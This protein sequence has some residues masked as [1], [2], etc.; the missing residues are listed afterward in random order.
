MIF[1]MKKLLSILGIILVSGFILGGCTNQP[2]SQMS[3]QSK[4]ASQT[5]TS[6][7]D[8]S[9]TQ[10]SRVVELKNGDSYDLI[11]EYA[12]QEI[13]G[14][15]YKMLAYNGSI[16]GP[17]LKVQQGSEITINLK[18]NTDIPTSLHSHGVRL[19]DKYDGVVDVQQ[20]QID[21]G[22][23]FTYKIKF[24]DA[25]MFWYHPH[26]NEPYTQSHGLYGAYWVVPND[27]NYWSP[28]NEEVPLMINDIAIQNG[29]TD[30][31]NPK[32]TN[33][34]LMGEFGN[35]MLVNGSTNYQKPLQLGEVIRLYAVNA[36]NTRVYNLSIPNV[37]MKLVGGDNGKYEHET[38][39]DHIVLSPSERAIVDVLF[40][41]SGSY[42][43]Q[44]TN[45]QNTYNLGTFTVSSEKVSQSFAKEF[46]TLRDNKDI[47]AD[48]DKYRDAFNKKPDKSITLTMEMK[49]MGNSGQHMM[50][51][52]QMMS[53]SMEQ[54]MMPNGQMMNNTMMSN[55]QEPIEW[56]DTM[57]MMNAMSTTET[58]KWKI[59]DDATKK[60]N[61]DMDWKFK[62][63][64][65]IKVK[66]YNDQN[67]M[68]PMQHPIHFHGQRFLVLSTNG[69]KNT[70]LVWKD[71]ALI[72][73]GATV[74]ILV[75]MSN[76]GKWMAH[77]HIAE[78]LSSGM[79]F[80]FAVN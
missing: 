48:I 53:N 23:T 73:K 65:K 47:I 18:N 31:F 39:Q 50:P 61:M 9:D 63:G 19:E 62:V 54:H 17:T 8:I 76:P 49:G 69:V 46:S 70:N 21:P 74:E 11:A 44:S 71:T 58:V 57:A 79:M 6:Q 36:S 66:I 78:H 1:L 55:D 15:I 72:P 34:A 52:G 10:E 77:C 20:K 13:N 33:Y 3:D 75:D 27:K 12:N 59:V 45:P 43:L 35:V 24:P 7:N 5:A 25:G 80:P 60:E 38:W 41:K 40:D 37:K 26:L 51:N 68:H 64:E 30:S 42:A 56:E 67:S 14:N 4:N 22:Q 28:V 29:R 16:P 32:V 2:E